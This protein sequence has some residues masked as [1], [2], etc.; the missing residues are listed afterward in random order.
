VTQYPPE[1]ADKPMDERDHRLLA[2]YSGAFK[3]K[4]NRMRWSLGE[5][6]LCGGGDVS[7]S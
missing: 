1:D 7:G 6:R 5:G 4:D 2:F 3:F